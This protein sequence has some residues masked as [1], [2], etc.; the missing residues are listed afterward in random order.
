MARRLWRVESPGGVWGG[1][2]MRQYLK[3]DFFE[4]DFRSSGCFGSISAHSPVARSSSPARVA[5]LLAVKDGARFLPEQLES[6][7]QQTHTDW[8]VHVSDDGSDDKT[9]DIVRNFA[10]R[11]SNLVTLRDGPRAGSSSN[12][13]S[14]LRDSSI[15][16]GYFAFSDQDDVWYPEKLER[17]LSLLWTA[18]GDQPAIYCSRTELIDRDGRHVGF[19]TD[20][21]KAP[22]F[23][24]ALVQSIAGGNT[25]VFNRAARELLKKVPDGNVVIHDWTTYIVISAAGGTIFY[26]RRPSVSY[27]QHEGNLFGANMSFWAR[28]RRVK[29]LFEG[30]WQEWN[31]IHLKALERFLPDITDENRKVLESFIQ[32]RRADGLPQRFWNLWKSGVH[33]Q[34]VLGE[35]G[36][37]LAV[38]FR[39]I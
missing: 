9:L 6:Y 17:A 8:S 33:R 37:L 26:D 39:K 16:A 24:N 31:S 10:S 23:R 19:S 2:S 7:A 14:L 20:F 5:I 11:V 36:L 3:R 34:T 12:F 29:M 22:S 18:P 25:M 4:R 27:R 1:G 21:K 28:A 32:M 38:M 13:L 15:D 35:L 30:Q